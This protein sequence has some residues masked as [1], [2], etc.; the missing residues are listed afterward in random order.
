MQDRPFDKPLLIGAFT[1]SVAALSAHYYLLVF[2]NAITPVLDALLGTMKALLL[3]ASLWLLTSNWKND[4]INLRVEFRI[5]LIIT[6]IIFGLFILGVEAL[7]NFVPF[8]SGI[9]TKV[10]YSLHAAMLIAVFWSGIKMLT[11]ERSIALVISGEAQ[12]RDTGE[13]KKSFDADKAEQLQR[14]ISEE[15]VFRVNGLSV[16]DLATRMGIKEYQLR[17]LINRTLGH[18][19]FT[20]FLNEY[21]LS[22]VKKQLVETD[23]PILSIALDAGYKSISPFNRAFKNKFGITPS[24]YRL[25]APAHDKADTE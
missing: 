8:Q 22:F 1:I 14:L 20:D 17:N 19:N 3:L 5:K 15:E 23:L 13:S 9:D 16:S 12:T 7:Q 18:R 24:Q 11:L 6:S 2:P 25:Q 10:N 21:R 4:L